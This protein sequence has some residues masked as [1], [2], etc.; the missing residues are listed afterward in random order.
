MRKLKLPDRGDKMPKLDEN[1]IK[2][3]DEIGIEE[4]KKQVNQMIN[5]YLEKNVDKKV[6]KRGNPIYKAM[7][8][9]NSINRKELQRTHSIPKLGNLEDRHREIITNLLIRW[10]IREYNYFEEERDKQRTISDF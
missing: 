5:I 9:C 4:L 8:A 2:L 6:P 1:D 3:I 10:I 7:H